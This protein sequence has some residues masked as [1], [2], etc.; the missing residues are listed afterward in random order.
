MLSATM[1]P[2]AQS[3]GILVARQYIRR[4][5]LIH[6]FGYFRFDFEWFFLG[7]SIRLYLFNFS[8]PLCFWFRRSQFRQTKP[9]QLNV[10][11]FNKTRNHS[12]SPMH[13]HRFYLEFSWHRLC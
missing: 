3:S 2:H 4:L 6:F 8:K 13:G 11:I 1:L 7:E 5:H 9:G 12:L 10:K